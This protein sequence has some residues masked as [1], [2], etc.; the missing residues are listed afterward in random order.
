MSYPSDYVR[1]RESYFYNK[2]I[3]ND[4]KILSIGDIHLSKNV[5]LESIDKILKVIEMNKPNYIFILGDTVDTTDELS[6]YKKRLLELEVLLNNCNNFA[7][8]II[9][10]GNHDIDYD[11]EN[12]E[13][14]VHDMWEKYNYLL[15]NIHLLNDSTYLDDNLFIGGYTQKGEVYNVKNTDC[16]DDVSFYKDLSQR[17]EL[18]KNIPSDKCKI[19]LTHSPESI[20][21]FINQELLKEYDLIY[22]AHYHDGVV[23]TFLEGLF[24]RNSGLL[25]PKRKKF[26]SEARG[27]IRLDTG[28]YL[29][30]NGGWTK[31][32]ATAKDFMQKFDKYFHRDIDV[33]TIGNNNECGDM[34]VKSKKLELIRK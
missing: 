8:T 10:L 17:N 12:G 18:I 23:P 3:K 26:P 33:T 5:E 22:T 30:Y 2:N 27:I 14:K 24:P 19:F 20:K 9:I 29:I 4:I 1:I 15:P 28:S 6:S 16:E 31:I 21:S 25:T 7:P 32:P 34:I 13:T 11:K